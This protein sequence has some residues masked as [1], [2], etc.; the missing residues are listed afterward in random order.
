M[1]MYTQ[2]NKYKI[3]KIHKVIMTS[4]CAA[5]GSFCFKKSI[6]YI[7]EKCNILNAYDMISFSSIIFTECTMASP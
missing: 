7:L 3:S 1:P 4:A 2:L 6:K 5:I